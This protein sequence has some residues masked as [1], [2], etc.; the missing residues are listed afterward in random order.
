MDQMIER[1]SEHLVEYCL[2]ITDA[3]DLKKV[4]CFY[5]NLVV[6][7][8]VF[9]ICHY[10]V[11]LNVQVPHGRFEDGSFGFSLQVGAVNGFR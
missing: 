4:I 9:L 2:A 3:Q 10:L 8:E 6:V 5:I 1:L 11:D 7:V